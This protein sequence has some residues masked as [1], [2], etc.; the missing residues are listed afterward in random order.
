MKTTGIGLIRS[1]ALAV[2]ANT[3]G[4]WISLV[5]EYPSSLPSGV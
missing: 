1:D 4:D 5:L 3:Y 2:A